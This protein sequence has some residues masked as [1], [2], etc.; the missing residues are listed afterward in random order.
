MQ[1]FDMHSH[2]LPSFDDGARTIDESLGL[3]DC[4]KKQGVSN[5]CFTPH[6]Y[7][8]EMS[9]E[10]FIEKRRIAYEEFLPYKPVNMNIVLGA[11][12]YVSKFLFNSDDLSG[13]T[14]GKSRYI[15]T[16]FSY[17]SSFSHRTLQQLNM[18]IENHRLIPVLPHVERY[19]ML[20]SDTEA[21]QELRDMGVIIQTNIGKYAKK[22]P[23]LKRRKLL[24]LIGEG[25]I[26]ILGS[27]AHSM[28][29][30]T[31]EVYSQAVEMIANKCG[32]RTV[33]KMMHN[34]EAIF[35]AALGEPLSE[36][37]TE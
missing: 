1:Y 3:L 33:R 34:A 9:V 6:F 12:V 11:E 28:T 7:T 21:L 22:A 20:M 8:N 30:N 14:Y 25:M 37:Y 17:S 2:I 24:K 31:P 23:L 36:E 13:L 5:V 15:L 19:E 27:D 10:R 16:E 29:H 18:L 32:Q 4:L 35:T 26:D